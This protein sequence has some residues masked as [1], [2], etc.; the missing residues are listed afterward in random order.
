MNDNFKILFLNLISY[1]LNMI[2]VNPKWKNAMENYY[3]KNGLPIP[4]EDNRK[5]F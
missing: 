3:R 1:A 5:A 4:W 2:E